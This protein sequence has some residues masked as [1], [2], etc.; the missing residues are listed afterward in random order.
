M[1]NKIKKLFITF[2]FIVIIG[3]GLLTWGII[4]GIGFIKNSVIPMFTNTNSI[5][6]ADNN[7]SDLSKISNGFKTLNSYNIIIASI[8][9]FEDVKSKQKIFLINPG[10]FFNVT[11]QDIES[12][13]IESKLKSMTFVGPV[14]VINFDKLQILKKGSFNINGQK[15]PYAKANF[16]SFNDSKSHLEGAIG[17]IE[18]NGNNNIFISAANIG[19]FKI[20]KLEK[21][22]KTLK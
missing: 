22:L 8:S 18:L 5:S 17:V 20:D 16:G 3:I 15:V 9:T 1:K 14:Q 19:S 13:N 4:S 6:L 7:Q 10:I 12:N 2:I 21:F 11:K